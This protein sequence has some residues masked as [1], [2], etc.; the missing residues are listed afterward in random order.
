MLP[1]LENAMKA[2]NAGVHKIV[3]GK[4]EELLS[5]IKG[6]TGTTINHE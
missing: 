4:A 3:I 2:L 1:K 6:T 5:L